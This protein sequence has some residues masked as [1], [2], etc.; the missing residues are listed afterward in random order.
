MVV[1]TLLKL[2]ALGERSRFVF[3][4]LLINNLGSNI[5]NRIF[6]WIQIIG[7]YIFY[8]QLLPSDQP[9]YTVTETWLSRKSTPSL[10]GTYAL[11][12]DQLL[13]SFPSITVICYEFIQHFIQNEFSCVLSLPGWLRLL[14]FVCVSV[15]ISI[16]MGLIMMKLW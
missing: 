4:T 11:T 9:E 13:T 14:S 8:F 7:T 6:C 1:Q 2:V 3:Q 12:C 15:Y 16:N 5:S 10:T